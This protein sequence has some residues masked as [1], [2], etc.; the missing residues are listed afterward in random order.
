MDPMLTLV[1]LYWI[2]FLHR[3]RVRDRGRI[4]IKVEEPHLEVR[5]SEYRAVP[6]RSCTNNTSPSV[7]YT[8]LRFKVADTMDDLPTPVVTC[9][10]D[11][12]PPALSS[13][14]SVC[15]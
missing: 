14:R 15:V 2:H 10:V 11:K 5:R 3:V 12:W 9:T 8:I 1:D 7:Y 4:E 13:V 6:K